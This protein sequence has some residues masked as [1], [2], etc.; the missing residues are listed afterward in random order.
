MVRES[1]PLL[2]STGYKSART[3]NPPWLLQPDEARAKSI[4]DKSARLNS[5][6]FRPFTQELSFELAAKAEIE[7]MLQIFSRRDHDVEIKRAE[8]FGVVPEELPDDPLD[9]I[10][11]DRIR[12]RTNSDAHAKVAFFVGG[13]VNRAFRE[14]KSAALPGKGAELP[15]LSKPFLWTKALRRTTLFGSHCGS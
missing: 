3:D 13:E 4:A 11:A 1:G 5:F 15:A 14:A 12:P 6:G 2:R 9:S 7:R 8:S 10:S